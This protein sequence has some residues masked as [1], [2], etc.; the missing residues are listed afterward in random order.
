M[1]THVHVVQPVPEEQRG[2]QNRDQGIQ[3][4]DQRGIRNEIQTSPINTLPQQTNRHTQTDLV[5]NRVQLGTNLQPLPTPQPV[6]HIPTTPDILPNL[7][8]PKVRV[9]MAQDENTPI[10][11]L[12]HARYKGSGRP[13]KEVAIDNQ[14]T[15]GEI[16]PKK[17]SW[18]GI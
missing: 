13:R 12:A 6:R 4:G 17:K 16:G 11:D 10:I 18:D 2:I 15:I 1:S 9:V 14:P 5:D 3:N 8:Q 7:N